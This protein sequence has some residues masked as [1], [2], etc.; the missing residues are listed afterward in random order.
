MPQPSTAMATR[1]CVMAGAALATLLAVF[2]PV[3]AD[4]PLP[5]PLPWHASAYIGFERAAN[6]DQPGIDA[7]WFYQNSLRIQG[8]HIALH[9]QT[10]LCASGRVFSSEG[11][12]GAVSYE[13]E[14]LGP[15]ENGRAVLRYVGCDGCIPPT[16][17]PEPL[18]LPIRFLSPD[19]I[20]LGPVTYDRR[21]RP[22]PDACPAAT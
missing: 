7:Q 15:L 21:N 4:P 22:Y 16:A 12:G 19:V 14:V 20:G 17:A 8:A 18:D 5:P 1:I 9:K 3:R 13:G 6:L 10:V 11:D 2:A